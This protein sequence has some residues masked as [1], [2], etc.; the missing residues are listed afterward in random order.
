MSVKKEKCFSND[1]TEIINRQL[2]TDIVGN[3]LIV[4]SGVMLSSEKVLK[5]SSFAN[6]VDNKTRKIL[7]ENKLW[8]LSDN[9]SSNSADCSM[10]KNLCFQCKG[11]CVTCKNPCQKCS[12]KHC[13]ISTDTDDFDKYL[14]SQAKKIKIQVKVKTIGIDTCDLDSH[15]DYYRIDRKPIII[16]KNVATDCIDLNVR[17]IVK[18]PI[19][20]SI[21]IDTSDLLANTSRHFLSDDMSNEGGDQ[22]SE[23]NSFKEV[24]FDS[25]STSDESDVDLITS[26]KLSKC[27][28][29]AKLHKVSLKEIKTANKVL[30]K[31]SICEKVFDKKSL[32][33]LHLGKCNKKFLSL[34]LLVSHIQSNHSCLNVDVMKENENITKENISNNSTQKFHGNKIYQCAFCSN[35]NESLVQFDSY[36]ALY[37]HK[38]IKHGITRS[39]IKKNENKGEKKLRIK[40]EF[41]CLIC[42]KQFKSSKALKDHS[43]VHTGEK[44]YHC[45][46]CNKSYTTSA[47]L[48]IH[49]R[50]HT[51]A[52]NFV[53]TVCNKAFH[54]KDSLKVHFRKHSGERPFQCD[55]CPMKFDRN[56]ILKNHRY[57]HFSEKTFICPICGKTFTTHGGLNNHEKGHKKDPL[58]KKPRKPA[59]KP[60]LDAENAV[61]CD[62]CGKIYSTKSNL[63]I[64]KFVHLG[65][66]PFECT[67]C[68]QT[69]AKKDSMLTHMRK[70]TD[71]RPFACETCGMTFYRN[72]TLKTHLLRH[73]GE[74][75]HKCK[76]CGKSFTQSSSLAYHVKNH[77]KKVERKRVVGNGTGKPKK[78]RILQGNNFE[79]EE[80][81]IIFVNKKLNE[82]PSVMNNLR[83]S[84]SGNLEEEKTMSKESHFAFTV[85]EK[86][87]LILDKNLSVEFSKNIHG[88]KDVDHILNMDKDLSYHNNQYNLG[89]F[90]YYIAESHVFS[91]PKDSVKVKM[92][93]NDG[94]V[95]N[96]II[97]KNSSYIT[98]EGTLITLNRN[99][100]L[101]EEY[102]ELRDQ[103][104]DLKG[105]TGVP[106]SGEILNAAFV[107]DENGQVIPFSSMTLQGINADNNVNS[108]ISV[109]G[110]GKKGYSKGPKLTMLESKLSY[111]VPSSQRFQNDKNQ[112][113][114]NCH[115]INLKDEKGS[116]K[117]QIELESPSFHYQNAVGE[118]GT[119]QGIP[120]FYTNVQTNEI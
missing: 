15:F 57:T 65:V 106:I 53:C 74:R 117:I 37:L 17:T 78:K 68:H 115:I 39:K 101:K 25:C 63:R 6:N 26:C 107:S 69:Y 2:I 93:K 46:I 103:R 51:G 42:G 75:P 95:E 16:Q 120:G 8:S 118:D 64:H 28:K 5:E 83:N 54:K 97:S 79:T 99:T 41:I 81:K 34:E 96:L 49:K 48:K 108:V 55:L 114:S 50:T 105:E 38:K 33:I 29:L 111:N 40:R 94:E 71:E 90:N 72:H 104:L 60:T 100:N 31:C 52:R 91:V 56:Y 23:N 67:I 7:F 20:N 45:D 36:K 113:K 44:N 27:R 11:T 112:I 62:V 21:G 119:L 58:V 1:N 88:N 43:P 110:E 76:I 22:L 59:V 12:V 10:C 35:E 3:P 86:E 14:D 116:Q 98:K 89:K 87:I 13:N 4:H 102:L 80:S 77:D 9:T 61:I 84:P 73:T 70:H 19:K 18:K 30:F 82:E 24:I 47:N 109:D 92:E 66:K 85:P 32:G